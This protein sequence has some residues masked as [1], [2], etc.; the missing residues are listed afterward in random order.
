M[1]AEID[2]SEV[3]PPSE[4]TLESSTGERDIPLTKLPNMG[5]K[6]IADSVQCPDKEQ[7]D[8]NLLITDRLS[9]EQMSSQAEV[10][11][12]WTDED[13]TDGMRIGLLQTLAQQS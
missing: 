2:E 11:F 4:S 6:P 1:R 7:I 12:E 10:V 8:P 5:F 9:E 13:G 3:H